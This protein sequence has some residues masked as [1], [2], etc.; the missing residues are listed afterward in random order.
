MHTVP[1]HMHNTTI[2]IPSPEIHFQTVQESIQFEPMIVSRIL[3]ISSVVQIK[4]PIFALLI[5]R[6]KAT[7]GNLDDNFG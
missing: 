1:Q 6:F 2:V 4:L 5:P 7:R 3:A